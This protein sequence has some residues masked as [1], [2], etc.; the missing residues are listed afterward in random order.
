MALQF[1]FRFDG[2][3]RNALLEGNYHQ[4][5][6]KVGDLRKKLDTIEDPKEA[7]L[8]LDEMSRAIMEARR[9]LWERERAKKKGGH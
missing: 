8:L 4:S 7:S 6:E 3:S 9:A 2:N 5:L 1:A